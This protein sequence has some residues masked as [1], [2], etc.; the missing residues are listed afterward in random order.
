MNT[1]SEIFNELLLWMGSLND[2]KQGMEINDPKLR[3]FV[4]SVD[5]VA[6]FHLLTMNFGDC[7]KALSYRVVVLPKTRQ[8][9]ANAQRIGKQPYVGSPACLYTHRHI[10]Q[11]LL[12]LLKLVN[13][14]R[15]T[16]EQN[17][18]CRE[19]MSEL[20]GELCGV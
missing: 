8:V 5:R 14:E 1:Q 12:Q 11:N 18:T 7:V 3:I 13:K 6:G 10:N 17:V 19:S 9:I 16:G 4:R 2:L 15:D 20:R